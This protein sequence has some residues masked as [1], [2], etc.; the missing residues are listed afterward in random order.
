MPELPEVE[1]IKNDLKKKLLDKKISQVHV[2][3]K[4]IV[5]G[6]LSNFK[7]SLSGR[8]F[9]DIE[10]IGKLLIFTLNKN[11]N[12][13]LV[14]LKMTGQLIYCQDNNIIAGGHSLPKIQGSL[15]NKYSHVYFVFED[16]AHLFFNDMRTF[17]YMKI[18]S[19]DRLAEIKK[20]FGFEPLSKEFNLK[21]FENLLKGRKMNIKAFLLNQSFVAGIGNIY[22]DEILYQAGILPSRSAE[23]L[24]EGEVGKIFQVIKP[25]LRAAIK[26]R[27]TTFND[28]VDAQ[29]NKGNYV[30]QLKVF[31]KDG[32]E[33]KKCG[34]IIMKSKVAGRGTHF[35]SGCQG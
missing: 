1:T 17:G 14:H 7:V 27:G 8:R 23:T 26:H 15:P 11:D 2:G 10:R 13:L 4:R 9:T 22:A 3:L 25:I 29:G 24:S 20:K 31:G 28:Y 32:S 33:C 12:F 19:K 34:T 30:S 5:K 35:C 21:A 18:V 6:S 16:G